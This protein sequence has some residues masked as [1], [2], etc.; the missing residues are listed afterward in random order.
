MTRR[1]KRVM[2]LFRLGKDRS[3]LP[4]MKPVDRCFF[5][6][7]WKDVACS[8]CSV[9]WR[10]IGTRRA[11]GRLEATKANENSLKTDRFEKITSPPGISHEMS[12]F[13]NIFLVH[14][15]YRRCFINVPSTNCLISKPGHHLDDI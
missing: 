14:G 15:R 9:I 4:T 13:R 8:D 6:G 7:T 2:E 3:Y 11:E 5:D 12:L 1:M 10:G